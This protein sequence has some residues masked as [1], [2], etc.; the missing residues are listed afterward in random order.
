MVDDDG[1][2][3]ATTSSFVPYASNGDLNLKMNPLHIV[4]TVI[5]AFGAI[6]LL[7]VVFQIYE[8]RYL[9]S[10][11]KVVSSDT[12]LKRRCWCGTPCM[13]IITMFGVI[14]AFVATFMSIGGHISQAM[15]SHHSVYLEALDQR[16]W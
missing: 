16:Y 7:S 8:S 3:G 13:G 10:P 11:R 12:Y 4:E 15:G 2:A 9:V 1:D 5:G 14:G 6:W